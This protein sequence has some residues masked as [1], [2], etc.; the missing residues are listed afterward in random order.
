MSYNLLITTSHRPSY[1]TRTFIKD[2]STALPGTIRVHRGKKTLLELAIEAKRYRVKYIAVVGEKKGNPS[3]IRLY[4]IGEGHRYSQDI[5]K[6]YAT[7]VMKGVSLTRELPDSTRAYNPEKLLIDVDN[8]ITDQCYILGDIFLKIYSD[9]IDYE[10]Y[11]VKIMFIDEK[12]VVRAE[13]RSRLNRVCG[14][15][16]RISKVVF[17]EG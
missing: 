17:F 7:I 4:S 15:I 2:F 14:P 16:L 6:H 13:I 10:R 12:N 1:R 5:L 11:D 3:M 9:R 8:C